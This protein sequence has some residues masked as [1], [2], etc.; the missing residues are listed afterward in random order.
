MGT[1]RTLILGASARAEE[2]VRDTFCLEL[3]DQKIREAE[4]SLKHAKYALAGLIQRERAE[5]RQVASLERSIIDLT[6]RAQDALAA[7]RED[8]AGQA[9]QAI[10]AMEN[11]VTQ[12]R[13]TVARLETRT[14]QLRQSVEAAHRRIIDLKQGAVA[15]RAAKREQDIQKR[16][17][18][19]IAQDTA[20]EDAE[21]LIKRVLGRDDPFEQSEILKDIETS[22]T[23]SNAADRLS[24]AGFGPPTKSTA[25]DVMARL[26]A[27]QTT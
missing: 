23:H 18:A 2:Q 7:G 5:S 26:K 14:L 9:A 19:H 17:G 25:D 13:D 1:L 24:E 21:A 27:A 4:T 3:I 16:L 22:L 6:R 12:R 10:A 8:L 15:A 11:E 20:F